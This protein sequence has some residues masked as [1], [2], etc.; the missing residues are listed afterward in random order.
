MH[1]ANKD[2]DKQQAMRLVTLY[3]ARTD[4]V[5]QDGGRVSMP[6]IAGEQALTA[7]VVA[8]LAGKVR[9]GALLLNGGKTRVGAID[10]DAHG[11][12][13][14]DD[15][16]G[17]AARAVEALAEV[18]LRAFVERTK[19]APGTRVMLYCDGDVAASDVQFVCRGITRRLGLPDGVEVFPKQTHEGRGF[20]NGL[21][22]RYF[23]ADVPEGRTVVLG[24]NGASLSLVDFLDAAEGAVHSGA[25]IQTAVQALGH[26]GGDHASP[27]AG[28]AAA[29]GGGLGTLFARL[30]RTPKARRNARGVEILCPFHPDREPS[31]IVFFENARLFC[32]ACA[33]SWALADW[34]QSAGG[35]ELVGTELTTAMSAPRPPAAGNAAW[36]APM[37]EE[38]FC[39]L[40]GNIVKAIEPHSEA[41]PAAL[42]VQ[43]LAAFGSVVGRGPSFSVEADRHGTNLFAV[44]VGR[45][46]KARKGTS[47]GQVA[48]LFALVDP[49]WSA[50]LQ[51]GLATGEGLVWAVRDPIMKAEPVKA[52]GRV[53]DYEQVVVDPGVVDKR[54]MAIESEFGRS[55]RVMARDGNTLS[56][57]LRQAWDSGSLH[58]LTKSS[59]AHAT[60]AHI[61]VI[62]H[63]TSDEL[64][65]R[66]A[67]GDQ[68]NGF[69]N[70]FLWV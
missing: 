28:A 49:A 41:D 6:S 67:A 21:W 17:L 40:A 65:E 44:V 46:S 53:V 35:I 2:R 47:W 55:L 68:V 54:L 69:A 29:N 26:Q 38:A 4:K 42:L 51:T 27:L 33:S 11:T 8:H 14:V 52:A 61:S 10:L 64:R 1:D 24:G 62:G 39:G 3:G 37:R 22:F 32:S 60:G 16:A 13:K 19:R 34:T 66:L 43:L 31:A 36:P 48:R 56:A 5:L 63:V 57:L 20:G 18:G 23:G 30:E 7:R 9:A 12:N 25:E 70:R 59:P 58:V 45:S 50:G 15:P